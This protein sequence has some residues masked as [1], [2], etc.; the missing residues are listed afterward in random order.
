M[1]LQFGTNHVKAE[2]WNNG[3][4]WQQNCGREFKN[5]FLVETLSVKPATLEQ[6]VEVRILT[7]VLP[8]A[9]GL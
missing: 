6:G 7:P 2:K 9:A 3:K 8:R 5:M 4:L 1:I